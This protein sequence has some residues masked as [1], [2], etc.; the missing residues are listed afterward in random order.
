M[1]FLVVGAGA[2]GGGVGGL[3]HAA[4]IDVTLVARGAHLAALRDDG[5]RLRVGHEAERVL[6]VPV[7]GTPAEAGIT[8][9]TVVLLAVKSQQT[10]AA[11]A[12]LV[13]HLLPATPVVSLQNGVS[14]ERTLL[15]HVEHVQAVTVMMP[16]SHLEPGRVRLHSAGRPG[17]L[18]VGRYPTGVDDTTRRVA[19][20]L[21]AAGFESLPRPDV[22]ACKHRKLLTNLGNAVNAACPPGEDADALVG[23]LHAEAD[24]VLAAAGV[25]VVSEAADTERRGDLLRPLVD[26]AGVGSSTWQSVRRGTGDVEVD[27]LNG[28]IV[29][30]GRLHGVPTPANELVRRTL[31]DVVRRGAPPQT[32]PAA[33]LLDEL[34]AQSA[35]T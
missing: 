22:M 21:T 33:G 7:V 19:A 5:L 1:R 18:D 17:L 29:L 9:D 8:D 13:P 2:I 34:D 11:L 27:H 26:R 23:R 25:E 16:S 12:D 3:L 28:E 4:G 30:L 14:N 15:R 20:D 10:A 35:R 31:H 6:A 24:V 32:V